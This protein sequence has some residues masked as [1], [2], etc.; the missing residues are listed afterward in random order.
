MSDEFIKTQTWRMVEPPDA[1]KLRGGGRISPV[2]VAFET[3]GTLS[4]ER[5]NAV[6]ICHAL[7]GDSHVTGQYAPDD[8]SAWWPQM[9]G[10]GKA[11]DTEKYFVI[12]ANIIGGC[13][14]TTGPASV[15]PTTG[16][17]YGLTFPM[18]T[19]SDMVSVQHALLTQ[20]LGLDRLLAAV[21]GSMGGMQVLQWALDHPEMLATAIPV[22]STAQLHAQGIAFDEVG[23][24]AICSDPRWRDGAYYDSEPPERGL[25]I[26][27][28]IGHITY[29]SDSSMRAKFGRN[30]QDRV[31]VG[32]DF[33]P[34]DFQV[35]SY[36]RYQGDKFVQRFDANSY[37]YITKAMD[38][39]DPGAE[40]GSLVEAL[41][42]VR[43]RFLIVSYSGDWLF[44]TYMSKELVRALQANGAE[45]T[46]CELQSEYGHDAFL[47]DDPELSQMVGQFLACARADLGAG[48]LLSGGDRS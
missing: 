8:K 30:L 4:P 24:Q 12:C 20:H 6:L 19:I 46:F 35:E 17:P 38:Y 42:G 16:Q 5:D 13:R 43:S 41:R 40:A 32:Y 15:D 9:V 36:L 29:L 47:L 33:G 18:V 2:D 21:G 3:A 37:L 11:I 45:T 26:A 7:T 14:G 22:A 27:R 25:A 44:P 39:Y 34:A 10:P 1:L 31:E 23:R 48:K 28:M